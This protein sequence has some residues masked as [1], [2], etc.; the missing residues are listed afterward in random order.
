LGTHGF[1]LPMRNS[2]SDRPWETGGL[3]NQFNGDAALYQSGIVLAGANKTIN[4]WGTS[5]L[6]APEDDGILVAAEAAQLDLRGTWLVTLSACDTGMGGVANG[7]ALL[8]AKLGFLQAGAQNVCFS[9]WR[10]TDAYAPGFM[11]AFYEKALKSGNAS[12]AL[13]EVQRTELA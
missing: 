2:A 12:T 7:E 9:L 1:F 13:A 4:A 5:E 10:V 6:P 11:R 8:G 3:R